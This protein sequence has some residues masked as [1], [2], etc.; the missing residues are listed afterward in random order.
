MRALARAKRGGVKNGRLLSRSN[1]GGRIRT[2]DLLTPSQTRTPEFLGDSST[3]S[4]DVSDNVSDGAQ[5]GNPEAF[6]RDSKGTQDKA[7]SDNDLSAVVAAW[8]D[9]PPAI[10][11]GI[12]A[13]VNAARPGGNQR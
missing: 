9:L 11:A 8:P 10:R 4:R 5:K 6:R 13:M 3:F 7:K 2:A 1:R 12:V